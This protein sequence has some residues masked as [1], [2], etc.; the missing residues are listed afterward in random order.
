MPIPVPIDHPEDCVDAILARCGPVLRAATPLGLGKPNGL[1]NALYRRVAGNPGLHLTLFTA[2]TL[3]RPVAAAGLEARFLDPFLER[4]FGPGYEDLDYARDMRSGTLPPNVRVHEFYLQSG[5]FV[6]ADA[7]QRAY[8]SQNYTHVAR[9]LVERDINL[10]LQRVALRGQDEALQIS[11]GSNPDVTPDLL[12]RIRAAGHPRPLMVAVAHPDMPFTGGGAEVAAGTF[13]LLLRSRD[14]QPPLFALPREPVDDTEYAIGFHASA[15]V[16]DGGTLQIGIGALSDA[17]VRALV[18]RQ[19]DNGRFRALL[20]AL[21]P[22]GLTQ[23]KALALGGLDSFRTGLY[24]VS[25]M[26][27]DGFMQLR[28]CGILKRLSYDDLALEQALSRD[29]IQNPLQCG[30][31]QALLDAGVL[32]DP[33][34]ERHMARLKR[35]GLLPDLAHLERDGVHLPDGTRL[36]RDPGHPDALAR[37]DG[38]LKGRHL[39]DGR[40]LRGAFFLGSHDFYRWMRE[41]DESDWRGLDM[42]RVSDVN[43]LYGGRETLDALQRR[44]ARFFNICMMA[45]PLGAVVSDALADGRVVSGVGGQ[46]NFVAMAHALEGGRSVL[47]LRSTRTAHGRVQSNIRWNYGHTTIPRHLRDIVITEYGIADLRGRSDEECVRAMLAI[48]DARFIDGLVAEARSAGKLPAAFQV[49]GAWRR[50]TPERLRDT[51]RP[52]HAEGLLPAFPLGSDFTAVEERLLPALA[53]IAEHADRWRG[54]AILLRAMLAPGPAV[55]GEDEAL[56]R[57]QL[58][59]VSGPG[60]RLQRGLL[61]AALRQVARTAQPG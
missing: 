32:P 18:L 17:L 57:M 19:Q 46:Y 14:R 60:E 54:R 7:V 5:A 44:D 10:V 12:D 33:L 52:F 11:L 59:R 58:D 50:N 2:L 8:I 37:W 9:D 15:L 55:A 24:G 27:M 23:R 38:F 41:L 51:L 53:W 26:V 40:Y 16:R 20:E 34:T 13:D 3:M 28:K 6:H 43:Q 49:P 36:P 42:T 1:L 22:E 30:A 61:R 25:E 4:H 56:Q 45:T 47:M 29:R 21:D 31:A 48:T 39:R 35:F